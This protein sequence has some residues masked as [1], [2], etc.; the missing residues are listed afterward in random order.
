[1]TH[2]YYARS[3]KSAMCAADVS[4]G[5]AIR[6]ATIEDA[7][8]ISGLIIPLVKKFIAPEF[9]PVGQRNLLTSMEPAAIRGFF[10]AGYRYH[11]AEIG[12]QI[13][14]VV[15]I[16]DN[17][18][19]HHLFVAEDFQR[20]GI[21]RRLREVARKECLAAGNPRR[22]TVYSSRYALKVYRRLGFVEAGLPETKDEVTTVPMKHE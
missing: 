15:G 20:R 9:S 21:A 8:A 14:G 1:M 16:R 22:F 2:V 5:V 4:I 11:V 12:G 10:E 18:H 6:P 3:S 19:V 7:E 13:V 17:S